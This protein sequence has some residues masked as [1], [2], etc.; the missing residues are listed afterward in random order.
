MS[1]PILTRVLAQTENRIAPDIYAG[2]G[3]RETPTDILSMMTK[4][5]SILAAHGF[6]AST[7]DAAG[8]DAAFR[9]GD[10]QA[11]VYRARDATPTTISIAH[12]LH[13]NPAALT[14]FTVKL[15]ARNTN[16]VFGRDLSFRVAFLICWTP[17]GCED[18]RTRS[19]ATGGT[20]QA[21]SLASLAG[22]PVFNLKREDALARLAAHVE[23]TT[24]T[25]AAALR[26]AFGGVR[27]A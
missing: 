17:D 8:A 14:D 12:E 7:G 11:I 21:I 18:H 13:P 22:R 3:S 15:M 2:V 4:I 1:R 9:A 27:A 10:A 16:Q 24:P 5:A 6:R 19:R 23:T 20:G 26:S 25:A